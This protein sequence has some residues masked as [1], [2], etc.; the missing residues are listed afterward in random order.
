[1]RDLHEWFTATLRCLPGKSALAGAIRYS[2]ARWDALTTL[3]LRDG[4]ACLDN[5]SAERAIRPVALGRKTTCS[6]GR[7]AG[8]S[9]RPQSTA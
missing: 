2:L 7:T 8:A 3:P 9:G 5:N 4:R 1:M 6:P